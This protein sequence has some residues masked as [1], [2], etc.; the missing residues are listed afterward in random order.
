MIISCQLLTCSSL[1]SST[2]PFIHPSIHSLIHM[3]IP[4]FIH[5]PIHLSIHH[6]FTHM[7]IPSFIHLPIY[8][9]THTPIHS[10]KTDT[11]FQLC[12]KQQGSSVLGKRA[13]TLQKDVQIPGTYAADS[14]HQAIHINWYVSMNCDRH[15]RD[16]I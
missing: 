2:Y 8:P 12:R 15:Q 14:R 1:H 5:L 6:S 9:L 11:K 13:I 7:L 10:S 16:V 4:S 3:L